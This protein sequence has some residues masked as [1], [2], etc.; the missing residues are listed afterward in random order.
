MAQNSFY[1]GKKI[2]VS[3]IREICVAVWYSHWKDLPGSNLEVIIIIWVWAFFSDGCGLVKKLSDRAFAWSVQGPGFDPKSSKPKALH[4][5]SSQGFQTDIVLSEQTLLLPTDSCW[6][7]NK[8]G[9]FLK[10]TAVHI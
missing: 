3:G 10:D 1:A 5:Q 6:W 9:T 7:W 2:R 8:V 4:E